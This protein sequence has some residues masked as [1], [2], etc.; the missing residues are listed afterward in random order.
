MALSESDVHWLLTMDRF[1][2]TERQWESC[3]EKH[4]ITPDLCQR[5]ELLF[6]VLRRFLN[7]VPHTSENRCK[8]YKQAITLSFL[9]TKAELEMGTPVENLSV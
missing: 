3:S 5:I 7:S 9:M 2:K 4:L 6:Q 1:K 8:Y